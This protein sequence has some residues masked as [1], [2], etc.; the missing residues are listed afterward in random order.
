MPIA[1]NRSEPTDREDARNETLLHGLHPHPRRAHAQSQEPEPRPAAAPA[2][3]HHRPLRLGQEL[4]RVRHAVRGRAA[5]LRRVAVGVRAAVPAADG[6]ARRRPDRR[7]VA[8]DLHRAEG[9]VAQPALDRGHRHRDPRLPAPPLRARRRS[10]LPRP[11]GAEAGGDDDLADGRRHARVPG[12]HAAHD[13]GAGDRQPEG[14][15]PRA[16]R[17]IAR[18]GLRARARRRQGVRDR[19]GAEARQDHQAHDRSGRRPAQGEPGIQAAPGRV[20]RDRAAPRRRPRDRRRDGQGKRAEAGAPV[21]RE[22][23]VS[24]SATIRWPNSSRASSR[25]TARSARARAATGWARSRSSIPS[26]SSRF[27]SSRWRPARSRAGTGATSS[28]SSCCKASPSM[29]AS[30]STSRSRNCPS[31]CS[32]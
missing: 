30:T 27:R 16:L 24:R 29:S 10:V 13:P 12:G 32:S 14:R 7:P 28:I 15:A 23:R 11:S 18:E 5:P 3:R 2:D 19:R 1:V 4:A 8:G 21:L 20:V 31:A 17:R 9:D 26:A 25:S 6:Q 22:I